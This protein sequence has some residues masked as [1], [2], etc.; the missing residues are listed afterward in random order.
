MSTSGA[1]GVG[2]AAVEAD[3]LLLHQALEAP[4][5]VDA[6]KV[7]EGGL[8]KRSPAEASE[9]STAMLVA[10]TPSATCFECRRIERLLALEVVV[11]QGLVD[12]G[13][14]G[15]LL[16][17]RAGEAVLAELGDGGVEDAGAGLV[18]ALSLGAGWGGCGHWIKLTNWLVS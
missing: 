14:F 15:D 8:R 9:S 13:R 18:S 16:G 10:R 11:E 3:H 17:A 5:G 12:A 6:V 7:I 1:E 2:L 4:V